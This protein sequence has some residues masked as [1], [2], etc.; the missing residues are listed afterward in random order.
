ML[1]K[2]TRLHRHRVT[3][4][5]KQL[6]A[7]DPRSCSCHRARHV[8]RLVDRPYF[9]IADR[10]I[11][12]VIDHTGDGASPGRLPKSMHRR[13]QK[14]QDQ[15]RKIALRQIGSHRIVSQISIARIRIPFRMSMMG[16]PTRIVIALSF[17]CTDV[18]PPPTR[19]PQNCE[20]PHLLSLTSS[21][22][23]SFTSPLSPAPVLAIITSIE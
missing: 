14:E 9:G 4:R 6:N 18:P 16:P 3:A 8:R 7:K 1:R 10:S 5:R 22:L 19:P 2:P 23:H 11:Y 20:P 21:L 13:N 17:F 15:G 12:G